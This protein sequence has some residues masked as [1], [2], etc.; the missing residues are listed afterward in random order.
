MCECRR[1]TMGAMISSLWM[2]TR[3]TTSTTTKGWLSLSKLEAW[4]GTTTPYGTVL[5]WHPL[6]LLSGSMLGTTGTSCWSSTSPW[7]WTPGSKFAC[8]RLVMESL[9][10]AGSSDCFC[11]CSASSS[12]LMM[13]IALVIIE[14]Q[15]MDFKAMYTFL[16][17]FCKICVCIF[18]YYSYA[19]AKWLL[20]YFMYFHQF[21][22]LWS[23]LSGN[24]AYVEQRVDQE[25][26]FQIKKDK[27]VFTPIFIFY[28]LITTINNNNNNNNIYEIKLFN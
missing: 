6:M 18:L 7:L 20:S 8:F 24:D 12:R 14:L 9:S 2:P 19:I 17:L 28:I 15:L 10:A 22:W 11:C 13:M 3:T 5:W 27:G 23:Q 16:L 26:L 21:G 4:S 1:R 25:L